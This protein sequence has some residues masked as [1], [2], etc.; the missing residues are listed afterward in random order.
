MAQMIDRKPDEWEGEARGRGCFSDSLPDDFPIIKT[1]ED[2]HT[3]GVEQD[4]SDSEEIELSD[5][6]DIEDPVDIEIYHNGYSNENFGEY[7]V[8]DND[9][10]NFNEYSE[11]TEN[12]LITFIIN[13][14]I[15]IIVIII[16]LLPTF[17]VIGS[18]FQNHSD[19]NKNKNDENNVE[20]TIPDNGKGEQVVDTGYEGIMEDL[21]LFTN[22]EL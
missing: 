2:I 1:E 7:L 5:E 19:N 6:V 18:H 3:T 8:I 12:S 15:Y 11:L 4:D 17:F 10:D 14:I 20:Y 16:I 21:F 22:G 13:I 9:I